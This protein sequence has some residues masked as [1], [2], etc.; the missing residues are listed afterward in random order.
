[1]GEIYGGE[2]DS[3]EPK[4]V[5]EQKKQDIIQKTQKNL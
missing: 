4:K 2:Y 1:M 3:E 5:N